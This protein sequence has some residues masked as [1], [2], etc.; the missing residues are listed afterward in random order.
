MVPR[1]HHVTKDKDIMSRKT[2]I[3]AALNEYDADS[4]KEA[5][6]WAGEYRFLH[7][8]MKHRKR[9]LVAYFKKH[10]RVAERVIKILRDAE[11]PVPR[12]NMFS[13]PETLEIIM[14]CESRGDV[15]SRGGRWKLYAKER[16]EL[17]VRDVP[18]NAAPNWTHTA[19]KAFIRHRLRNFTLQERPGV[20]VVYERLVG[21]SNAELR[22]LKKAPAYAAQA[23]SVE[24]GVEYVGEHTVDQQLQDK[25]A[26]EGVVDLI[27]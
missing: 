6:A 3:G 11:S 14:T 12:K 19:S 15:G 4:L 27:D 23:S 24:G 21:C 5:M 20:D 10:P 22:A 7:S 26:K 8:N 13:V 25:M 17:A 9:F 2:N 1:R 18:F 16:L